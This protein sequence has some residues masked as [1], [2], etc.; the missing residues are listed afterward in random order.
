MKMMRVPETLGKT[1]VIR[2]K[3]PDEDRTRYVCK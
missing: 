3:K 1:V 2:E